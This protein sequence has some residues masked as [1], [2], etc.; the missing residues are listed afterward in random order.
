[1]YVYHGTVSKF[2]PAILTEGL[3]P[4]QENSWNAVMVGSSKNYNPSVHD[5][6]GFV[7]VTDEEKVSQM[8]AESKS[9]YFKANQGAEFEIFGG[10]QTM[11]KA[12]D[13]PVETEVAPVILKIK[14][15]DSITLEEDPKSQLAMRLRGGISPDCIVDY[16]YLEQE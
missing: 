13:A 12:L 4:R 7:Y 2:L 14:L 3:Q 15:S 6:P 9:N 8:Y 5:E 10:Y 11:V 1:M 16:V